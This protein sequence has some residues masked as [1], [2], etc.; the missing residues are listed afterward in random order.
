MQNLVELISSL[1]QLIYSRLARS[2]PARQCASGAVSA[3]A[4]GAS[5][6]GMPADS[7]DMQILFPRPPA[8]AMQAL[9]TPPPP[10]FNYNRE[11]V[12]YPEDNYSETKELLKE[13]GIRAA[14]NLVFLGITMWIAKKLLQW[15]VDAMDPTSKEKVDAQ[16]R[17][18]KLLEQIG[19]QDVQLNELEL[20]LASNLVN[21][22]SIRVGFD[23]VG[24]LDDV[25]NDLGESVILPLKNESL[26]KSSKLLQPPKGVLLYGPPGCGKTMIAKATAREAGAR[27]LNIN[28]SSLLDKWYGESQ[29]RVEALFTLAL[30]IQP[31]IIFIDEIDSILRGRNSSD[32]EATAMM[33]TQ[34]MSLWDGL[35]TDTFSCRVIIMGATN[36]PSDLDEAIMRRM[37]LR[38]YIGMPE[39]RQRLSILKIILEGENVDDDIDLDTIAEVTPSFSGSDLK[40][41]CRNASGY[42]VREYVRS[43]SGDWRQMTNSRSGAISPIM[44]GDKFRPISNDDLKKSAEQM[45]KTKQKPGASYNAVSAFPLD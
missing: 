40:E 22:V 42:R 35:S 15:A 30:K 13:I 2:A 3:A 27:F 36:R 37:P 8:P 19:I 23:D 28:L 9:P 5:L 16:Q 18:D 44:S 17:A 10:N 39:T 11:L 14:Q 6:Q 45:L 1:K 43:G 31:T 33:K 38:F 34:F 20:A 26:F 7:S 41:L 25:I 32:H 24:G 21:P 29:K 12:P 4:A